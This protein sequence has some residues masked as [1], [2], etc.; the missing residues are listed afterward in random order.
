MPRPKRTRHCQVE[1]FAWKRPN[2]DSFSDISHEIEQGTCRVQV[3]PPE[4]SSKIGSVE[5]ELTV[6]SDRK[7]LMQQMRDAVTDNETVELSL[8]IDG[9][10]EPIEP[11]RAKI[12]AKDM[13]QGSFGT[14]AVTFVVKEGKEQFAPHFSY[15]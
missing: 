9:V 13:P 15:S 7:D 6:K 10:E 4:Y 5:V 11:R 8:S 2:E 1:S 12:D 14:P 3:K